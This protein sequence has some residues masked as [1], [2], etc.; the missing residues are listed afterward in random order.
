MQTLE[1]HDIQSIVLYAH[2]HL[3]HASY[4]LLEFPAGSAPK[5]WVTALRPRLSHA[6]HGK[7]ETALHLAFTRRG[8]EALG[9]PDAVMQTFP[10]PFREGMVGEHKTRML[11][12][13]EESAPECWAW[14]GPS[15][16]PVHALLMAYARNDESLKAL[17]EGLEALCRQHGVERLHR[18][19][20]E[21]IMHRMAKEHFGFRDGVGQPSV[22]GYGARSLPNNTMQAGEFV[23]G[24][25]NEYGKYPDAPYVPP[26]LDARGL[27][28]ED[29]SHPGFRS[30]GKNGSFLVFRQLAQQVP[31]FWGCM[32]DQ[33]EALQ[34]QGHADTPVQLATKIVGRWP[35]GAPLAQ[36]P[37]A[38]QPDKGT[39]DAF[40]Y[41][42]DPQG[43]KCPVGAHIRRANPRDAFADEPDKSLS[44][45]RK[46]RVIRRG[47]G[48]GAPVSPEF[49]AEEL[50]AAQPDGVDRGLHFICL[51]ANIARQFELVQQQWLN[52][53]KFL[54]QY[55]EVDPL[56]GYRPEMA[57]EVFNQYTI[58]ATP[59]RKRLEDL[60]RF[61]T[62]K[63]GEYFLLPS[64]RAVDFLAAL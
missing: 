8:L 36:Y 5:A 19:D 17:E 46:N 7:Q 54:G 11:G 21:P 56:V 34:R 24:Y 25:L 41:A 50:Q 16:R 52:N 61:V 28:P 51:N 53:P 15:N 59:L 10:L 22:Q 49:R 2:G 12:D 57:G 44:F 43:L 6:Q 39:E 48:Y 30:L 62:V 20:T 23:L 60:P 40:M 13:V 9:L 64:L 58:P 33:A 29:P 42:D 26:A 37:H 27:L 14:G 47:R 38:D 3:P 32:R 55:K 31:E 45:V 1:L 18:L 35:S 63:G 4:L